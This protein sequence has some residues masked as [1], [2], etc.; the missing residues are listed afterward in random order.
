MQ[1][2]KTNYWR[3]PSRRGIRRKIVWFVFIHGLSMLNK[4]FK[5]YE[6]WKGFF[7]D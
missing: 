4:A 6:F 2:K 7:D 1:N 3:T 5:L